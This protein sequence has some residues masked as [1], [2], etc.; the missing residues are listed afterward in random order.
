MLEE[1]FL[2]D[3]LAKHLALSS[4]VLPAAAQEQFVSYLML[5]SR[6]QETF[7]ITSIKTPEA[8]I[9][10]HIM[11]ALSII[12]YLQGNRF[13]DVGTG[14]GIPGIILAIA[15][16]EY[17]L[18][19]LDAVGKKVRFLQQVKVSLKL[20]NV[21]L[22]HSRVEMYHPETLFDGVVT[23]AYSAI[24]DMLLG[25]KHLCKQGGFFYAMKGQLPQDE[26]AALPPGFICEATHALHVPGL[27][28]ERH[29]IVLSACSE[30]GRRKTDW[31]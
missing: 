30:D 2:R 3:C 21:S 28:A 20:S 25:T 1:S 11:D 12:P 31:A 22:V 14:A 16:P 27:D 19:L 24:N 10:H 18:T 7:N 8:Q 29:L 17:E 5:M 9:T 4:V 13:I 15:R 23:R 6:W 26:L